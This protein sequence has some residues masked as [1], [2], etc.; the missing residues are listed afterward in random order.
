MRRSA[1]FT[2][3][4]VMAALA[5]GAAVVLAAHAAFGGAADAAR[6]LEDR[7]A[8]HDADMAGR[9]AVVRL[10][11]SL[12]LAGPDPA[13]FDGSADSV[14]FTAW[15]REPTGRFAWYRI[16]IGRDEDRLVATAA[17]RRGTRLVTRTLASRVATARFDYLLEV[18]ADER[19]VAGWRSPVSAP[20]AIRLRLRRHTGSADTLLFVVGRRG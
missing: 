10:I 18:G 19:W 13:G 1:G 16:A 8:T 9:A 14:R 11:A 3:I 7:R 17:D 12:D 4:E 5:I 2:L 6:A 15:V 20:A